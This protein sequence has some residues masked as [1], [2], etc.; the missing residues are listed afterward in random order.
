M[1]KLEHK[2]QQLWQ[3]NYPDI[4]W[5][6]D[7]TIFSDRQYRWDFV[8]LEAMVL[9]EIQGGVWVKSGH[10]TGMGINRDCEKMMLAQLRGYTQFN[11]TDEM[12][13][14]TT[15]AAIY[16]FIGYRLDQGLTAINSKQSKQFALETAQNAKRRTKN[17]RG[18]SSKKIKQQQLKLEQL[19]QD[20]QPDCVIIPAFPNHQIPRHKY[21]GI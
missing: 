3:I 2:F 21:R 6:K 4:I 1:S 5:L 14:Q 7:K 10:S 17:S 8:H 12:I 9:I 18:R 11:L 19:C 20:H 16:E 13:N 15:L